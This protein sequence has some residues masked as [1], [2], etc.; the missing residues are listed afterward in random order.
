M[1]RILAI[2]LVAAAAPLPAAEL[3]AMRAPG[4]GLQPQ[5][6]VDADGGVHLI[7]YRGADDAGDVW[8]VHRAPGAAA[9]SAPLR[10]DSVPG[11]AIAMGSIRGAQ[12]AL[13][14]DGW[15]HVAWN[16]SRQATPK[17]PKDTTPMLYAR[18]A[19]AAEAFEPQRNL[20]T[21]ASGLDGGG[22]VAAD[23]AGHV[24]VAWHAGPGATSETQRSVFVAA[25]K[26][27]GKT[28]AKEAQAVPDQTGACGCC[29]MRAGTDSQGGLA[30]LYRAAMGGGAQRDM[31]LAYAAKP[32]GPFRIADLEPWKLTSCPMST[33]A[34]ARAGDGLLVAWQGEQGL[35]WARIAKGKAGAP[36]ALPPGRTEKHPAIAT[37]ADGSIAVVWTEGTGWKQGGSLRWQLYDAAGKP[38]G[39]PGRQ[40]GVPAWSIP[41]VVADGP[42]H[43]SAWY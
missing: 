36:T 5:A 10:V 38:Q 4:D 11:S 25:S 12:L 37:A 21:W 34:I 2:L 8:Y 22:A 26:D 31:M 39:E 7:Y 17:G 33:A 24:T 20:M 13:G 9:F 43:F 16:G 28:F 29:G 23:E 1:H 27:D 3:I 14:R 30:L 19:A 42:A 35:S 40:D 15:V 18:K 6:A 32:G 41:T